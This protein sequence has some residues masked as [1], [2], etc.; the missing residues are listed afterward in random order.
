MCIIS[1]DISSFIVLSLFSSSKWFHL[2]FYITIS[3]RPQDSFWKP[4]KLIKNSFNSSF[5]LSYRF[6]AVEDDYDDDDTSDNCSFDESVML[7]DDKEYYKC[8][9]YLEALLNMA[10]EPTRTLIH[11]ILQCAVGFHHLFNQVGT[12]FVGLA[13]LIFWFILFTSFFFK[14][15]LLGFWWLV[16]N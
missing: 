8:H 12:S 15:L 11:G 10:Q 4:S 9:D 1:E 2:L 7:F 3:I 13:L 5:R 6:S 16:V 14:I